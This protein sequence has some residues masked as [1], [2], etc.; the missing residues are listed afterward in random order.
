MKLRSVGNQTGG[1]SV[2]HAIV[3]ADDYHRRVVGLEP[4]SD[5]CLIVNSTEEALERSDR[6]REIVLVETRPEAVLKHLKYLK[7][8]GEKLKSVDLGLI[9]PRRSLIGILDTLDRA[10]FAQQLAMTSLSYDE[11]R[12]YVQLRPAHSADRPLRDFISGYNAAAAESSDFSPLPADVCE[13]CNQTK[14]EMLSLMIAADE[15]LSH[16]S[17]TPT[18]PT[19]E[20]K[21]SQSDSD[22][23]EELES[24]SKRLTKVTNERDSLRRKY[25]SLSKSNLGNITLKYW[26]WRRKGKKA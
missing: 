1:C 15:A 5:D 20:L 23:E 4:F 16:L 13:A 14:A 11:T 19:S 9:F 18:A 6:Q 3:V 2:S 25:Y 24:L 21:Q 12:A 8:T 17:Y 26:S 10:D 7:S 22:L